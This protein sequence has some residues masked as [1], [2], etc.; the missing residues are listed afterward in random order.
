[1]LNKLL[2]ATALVF[3]VPALG[4]AGGRATFQ[5]SSPQTHQSTTMHIVWEDE[6]TLRMEVGSDAYMIVR[7]GKAYTVTMRGNKPVVMEMGGMMKMMGAIAKQAN[8]SKQTPFRKPDEIKA[9]GR[10]DTVAGIEGQVYVIN[11]TDANGNQKTQEVVLTDEPVVVEM[12]RSYMNA[13]GTMFNAQGPVN[14]WKSLPAEQQGLLR[15]G[16]DFYVTEIEAT[17]PPD[18][19]FELPAKP[20]SLGSMFGGAF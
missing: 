8:K 18:E 4:M 13:I 5:G 12:T 3:V 20:M 17:D 10:T 1:M 7:D 14:F 19:L 6:N 2:V 9:T 11:M 16:D 15:S